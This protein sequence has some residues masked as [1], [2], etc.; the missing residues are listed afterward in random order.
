MKPLIVVIVL[1]FLSSHF[2]FSQGITF[3]RNDFDSAKVFYKTKYIPD[4]IK[5]KYSEGHGKFKMA[6]TGGY[7]EATDCIMKPNAPRARL[8]FFA[9]MKNKYM[10]FYEQGGIGWC[11]YCILFEV[12]DE[13]KVSSQALDKEAIDLPMCK[14]VS[15]DV[16]KEKILSH[17]YFLH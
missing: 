1:S 14:V 16:L 17:N 15:Y 8:I 13:G 7:Y 9:K 4:F 2:A 10:L 5:Q 11:T 6:D 3:T 12:N